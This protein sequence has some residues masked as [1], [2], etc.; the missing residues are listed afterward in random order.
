MKLN[1]QFKSDRYF[2]WTVM[3]IFL[4]GRAN[5]INQKIF[6][7]LA[8]KM[9]AKAVDEGKIQDFEVLQLYLMILLE[10]KKVKDA[11]DIM[12]G[13]LGKTCKVEA[14]RHRILVDLAKSAER[15]DDVA[16]VSRMMLESHPDDWSSYLNYIEGVLKS[17]GKENADSFLQAMDVLKAHQERA[18]KDKTPIRGP[19]LAEMELLNRNGSDSKLSPVVKDYLQRFGSAS[20][21]FDD[22][23]PYLHAISLIEAEESLS[24]GSLTTEA[25]SVDQVRR[26]INLRKIRRFLGASG[27]E[28]KQEEVR[29]LLK[30]YISAI[31]L[32]QKLDERELQPGDDF[33]VLAAHILVDLYAANR[34]NEIPL[35]EAAA[36]LEYGLLRSKFNFQIKLILIRVYYELGAYQKALALASTLDIKH[37]QNDTLSFLF[38][39]DLELLACFD[40]AV[41]SFM[42]TLTIYT[43]NDRETPEMIVQAFKFATFSKI[44]EF[45]NFHERL[46]RSLQ[47]AVSKRQLLRVELLRRSVS[48]GCEYLRD[49][50]LQTD[51]KNDETEKDFRDNRD[52][53]VIIHWN[54]SKE[55]LPSI[56]HGEAFPRP[57]DPWL[58][59]QAIIP[60]L[61][62]ALKQ[63]QDSEDLRK[64]LESVS[65]AKDSEGTDCKLQAECL[66][67]VAAAVKGSRGAI[68]AA[69]IG[70]FETLPQ[71]I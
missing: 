2:F 47:R 69:S 15:W 27:K 42:K 10:Q 6:Y 16:S 65:F 11:I 14:E 3:C 55:D 49:V 66:A 22:L 9:M 60:Q 25:I 17:E 48:D 18:L 36:I 51:L 26:S 29:G 44:P 5:P 35:Y 39:D 32:G 68:D 67:H 70:D 46:G 24:E 31:P 54:A 58:Q 41:A 56:L 52:R 20:W 19:F 21:C 30:L 57:R 64:R 4:Q 38:T 62:N 50:D 23:R 37:I 8:E 13:P 43:S 53:T 63:N 61:L 40:K 33:L 45:L 28:Q 59:V 7:P 34:D 71:S 12:N 1:K